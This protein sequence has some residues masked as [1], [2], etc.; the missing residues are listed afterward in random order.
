VFA[1]M[2][3]LPLAVYWVSTV[4]S[5]SAW[6]LD[7]STFTG[8]AMYLSVPGGILGIIVADQF[9]KRPTRKEVPQ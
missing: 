5:H 9:I 3:L 2:V 7:L 1:G 8:L 6:N 4:V